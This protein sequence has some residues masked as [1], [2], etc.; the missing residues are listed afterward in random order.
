VSIRITVLV[1][2]VVGLAIYAWKD[3]YKSLCGLILLMAA[4]E[5]EDMPKAMF[6][7]HGLNMWNMLFGVILLAWL[8]S[9]GR[10]GLRWDLPRHV[11][12]LLLAY[13]GVILIG[14]LRAI[15][16]RGR[17]EGYLYGTR[18]L[19]AEELI[20]TIKWV[21]PGLLLFDG[22]RTRRQVVMAL[23]CVL[24]MY[25]AISILVIRNMPPQAALS[26]SGMLEMKRLKLNDRV[27][28]CATDL[29]V[30]LAGAC[31][32]IV[33]ALPLVRRKILKILVLG[34]AGVCAFGQALTGGRA[35]YLAW[36]FVGLIMCLLK[37][38]RQ[39]VLAPVLV[40][41]LAM[42][43]PG[44][45]GRMLQ[46]FGQIDASGA[47]TIDEDA[48]T[49][50]RTAVWPYV[51]DKI[52]QSFWVGHGRLAMRRTGLYSRIELERPGTGAPHP[53]NMYLETLLDNG[54]LGSL[55]IL[56]LWVVMVVA[57]AKL[58]RNGNRLY[59][60]VGG[61]SLALTVSSLF[62]GLA[63]QHVYPQEHTL[64]IW[65]AIFLM[66]RVHVEEMHLR[67]SGLDTELL[68]PSYHRWVET[69][70]AKS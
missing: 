25:L 16:D 60:A 46:G 64:G 65:A 63:G 19:I 7:I 31:W 50:D 51:V 62:A 1:V 21:L 59:S 47:T 57:S 42:I 61:L 53:H 48:V 38:R 70:A 22:C 3:W 29:S 10:D 40:L 17:M 44:V 34:A 26:D 23:V 20:N 58:F 13:A 12:I 18:G 28:Y 14:V 52:G 69:A 24:A 43:L 45:T 8:V 56:S 68:A 55:P 67:D 36:G 49:S 54:I 6:G 9:R 27:G 33:A 5:H 15:F 35:G 32:G 2:T 41:L 4:I 37:W 30:M 66:L 39:L 11:T